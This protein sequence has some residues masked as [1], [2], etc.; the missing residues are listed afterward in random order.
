MAPEG[1]VP[2]RLDER[3]GVGGLLR[4]QALAID[5]TLMEHRARGAAPLLEWA[6][7]AAAW[8]VRELWDENG[9][10]SPPRQSARARA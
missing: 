6:E 9:A 10:H 5:A 4:D 1:C 2:H 3:G 7:R 8:T